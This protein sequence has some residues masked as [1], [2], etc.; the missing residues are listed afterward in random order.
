MVEPL[1]R[2]LTSRSPALFLAG[3]HKLSRIFRI[4]LEP[5]ANEDRIK[6]EVKLVL[7]PKEKSFTVT[8]II[9]S[10]TSED[11]TIRSFTLFDWT[12]NRTEIE[13]TGMKINGRIDEKRFVF[14][15]PEGVEM[16]EMPK[17]DFG[18]D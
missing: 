15:K 11:F 10:V 17:L 5:A 16:V 3:N 7:F 18:A 4:E 12:G 9:L 1:G 14:K 8:R 2:I 13:F 6:N